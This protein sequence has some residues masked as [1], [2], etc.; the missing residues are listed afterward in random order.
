MHHED[1]VVHLC[2]DI[3]E[4]L[5]YN[6]LHWEESEYVMR[7]SL[8][9]IAKIILLSVTLAT[10]LLFSVNASAENATRANAATSYCGSGLK[11]VMPGDSYVVSYGQSI[12]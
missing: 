2:F 3:K 1:I 8:T 10:V 5:L 11:D 12:S 7:K 4:N 6:T 9:H